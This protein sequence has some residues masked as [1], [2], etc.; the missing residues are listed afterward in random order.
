MLQSVDH[1]RPE[2]V[3]DSVK[4]VFSFNLAQYAFVILVSA[5]VP[6]AQN[7]ISD[8][9]TVNLVDHCRRR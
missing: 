2:T 8:C 7:K 9:V 3:M 4:K 1:F 6:A 5:C